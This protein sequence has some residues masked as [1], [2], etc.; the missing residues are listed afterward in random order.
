M[1]GVIP[2]NIFYGDMSTVNASMMSPL[3]KSTTPA[4]AFEPV[5]TFATRPPAQYQQRATGFTS[6][7]NAVDSMVCGVFG[8]DTTCSLPGI[9]FVGYLVQRGASLPGEGFGPVTG[10]TARHDSG[11]KRWMQGYKKHFFINTF[12]TLYFLAGL[13]CSGMG[14]W[15]AIEGLIQVFGLGGTVATSFGCAVP[16]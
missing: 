6:Q 16:V 14:T 4:N 11:V 5:R 7:F 12:T 8:L 9:V 15:A 10:Q 1:S 2:G 3:G 13:G